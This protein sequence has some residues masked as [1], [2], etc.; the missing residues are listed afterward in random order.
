MST[1]ALY[2]AL[3]AEHWKRPRN[4]GELPSPD[5]AHEGTNPLCGDRVRI[6]LK[7]DAGRIALAHFRGDACM[8]ATAAASL[9][10]T[11]VRGLSLQEAAQLSRDTL[12]AALQAPLRPSRLA[13]AALPLEVLREAI[14]NHQRGAK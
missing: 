12:V 5:A 3:I 11:M 2:G 8:V 14:S 10:T 1:E 6:E 4:F 7:L 13:C 9:L